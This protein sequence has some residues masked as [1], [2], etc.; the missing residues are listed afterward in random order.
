M[1]RC[2]RRAESGCKVWK[3]A[4]G[5]ARACHERYQPTSEPGGGDFLAHSRPRWTLCT[6]RQHAPLSIGSTYQVS[7]VEVQVT[8][9][10]YPQVM[11]WSQKIR[12]GQIPILAATPSASSCCG[13][14]TSASMAFNSCARCTSAVSSCDHSD[15]GNDQRER[16]KLP[17]PVEALRIAIE[18]I[19]HAVF[20]QQPPDVPN[21]APVLAVPEASRVCTTCCQ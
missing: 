20:I 2:R 7:G 14:Y 19:G 3:K 21:G 8:A 16:I 10:R 4:P 11:T 1:A 6:I 18:V 13:P 12:Y 17:R 15:S 9:V 5:A